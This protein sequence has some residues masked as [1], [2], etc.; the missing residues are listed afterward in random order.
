[1]P[2]EKDGGMWA[3]GPGVSAQE[4]ENKEKCLPNFR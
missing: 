4:R 1:M 3:H 2:A